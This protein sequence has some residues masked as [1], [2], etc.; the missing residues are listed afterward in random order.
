MIVIFL[1]II[2]FF[3]I[4]NSQSKE[5]V[6]S[7]TEFMMDTM[8]TIK[9]YDKV[10]ETVLDTIFNRLKEIENRMSK[11]IQSSDVNAINEQAGIRPVCVHEDVY[12]V[13]QR[14]LY[15]AE[16]TDGAYDPTVGPLVEL[17]NIKGEES[18]VEHNIPK[19]DEIQ[20][21]LKKV[22]YKKLKLL[23][24]NKVLLR[25]KGM[26]ID[27]GGI[28]KGYAADEAKRILNENGVKSAIVDIGG[29]I[30]AY[31]NKPSGEDWKIGLRN[32]FKS[33]GEHV[34]IV[35]ISNTSIVTSGDYERYF[36]VNGK[37]YHHI[38]STITGYP[39]QNELSA[40]SVITPSSIDGDALST[41]LFVLG[42]E[43]GTNFLKNYS[44]DVDAFYFTKDKLIYVPN[45]LKSK[46]KLVNDEFSIIDNVY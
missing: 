29:N 42:I 1:L 43:R 46:F 37:R 19:E 33:T 2:L 16:L 8:V 12:F 20:K 27:L 25:D 39:V 7:R 13:I 9:I 32:P 11:T 10:D 28:V 17:W 41:A 5:V 23:N 31:G 15:F 22:N 45:N 38:L 21:V 4:T 6:K 3:Y 26:M 35:N 14:A 30:Y 34:G 40:V 24:G 18:K 44:N 36:E